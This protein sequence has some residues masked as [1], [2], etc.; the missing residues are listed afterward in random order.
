MLLSVGLLVDSPLGNF[1]HSSISF[2]VKIGFK[3]P[4]TSFSRMVYMKSHVDWPRVGNYLINDNWSM[5]YNCRNPVYE[6]IKVIT[7]K[8]IR[9][10]LNDKALF[11]EDSVPSV[12]GLSG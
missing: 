5:V 9:S 1:D 8:V 2:S 4:N 12:S 3:F 7:S 6:F 11:N 10:T